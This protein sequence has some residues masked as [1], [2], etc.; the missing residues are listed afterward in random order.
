MADNDQLINDGDHIVMEMEIQAGDD[1]SANKAEAYAVGQR[2][3]VDVP[4]TDP[5]Y[6]NNAKYYA[7]QA[8]QSL[9][10]AQDEVKNAEAWAKGTKGG[11]AVPDTDPT[12]HD[13]SKYWA[14]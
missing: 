3:G 7:E 12:Y 4:S 13:N 2:E 1:V 8:G 6:H 11:T 9:E 5:A 14:E 10:D